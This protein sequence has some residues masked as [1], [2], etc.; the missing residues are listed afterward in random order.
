MGFE[1]LEEGA[2]CEYTEGVLGG[3]E[4]SGEEF[5]ELVV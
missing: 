3:E 4:G 1:E 2:A 5:D